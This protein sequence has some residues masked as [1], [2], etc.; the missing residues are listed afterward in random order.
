MYFKSMADLEEHFQEWRAEVTH[1]GIARA[2]VLDELENHLRERTVCLINSGSSEDE[3]FR[4]AAQE[5]GESRVLKRE[6]AKLNRH[7]FW[8]YR[9]NPIA[10]KI[11]A[12]WFVLMGLT[13]FLQWHP[14]QPRVLIGGLFRLDAPLQ[15]L[16]GLGLLHRRNAWRFCAFG[17]AAFNVILYAYALTPAPLNFVYSRIEKHPLS[18]TP[19]LNSRAGALIWACVVLARPAVR[20]LFARR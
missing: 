11:L 16:I 10:L 9:D 4:A 17:W 7:R 2:E 1:A 5:L 6:F 13:S 15:I 8:G 14:A 18:A 12:V 20:N 3:A 19:L